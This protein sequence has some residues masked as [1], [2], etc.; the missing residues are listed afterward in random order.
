MVFHY[1]LSWTPLEMKD[2]MA[3]RNVGQRSAS[4]CATSRYGLPLRHPSGPF[5]ICL[6]HLNYDN[7]PW[8]GSRD[9]RLQEIRGIM[10]DKTIRGVFERFDWLHPEHAWNT[11]PEIR[12]LGKLIAH[13]YID[14]GC[15][16]NVQHKTIDNSRNKIKWSIKKKQSWT[17]RDKKASSDAGKPLWS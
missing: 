3:W 4:L 10:N 14:R 5:I 11:A 12:F 2:A 1:Y 17:H 13:T 8:P 7:L 16:C 15:G 6:N 9:K